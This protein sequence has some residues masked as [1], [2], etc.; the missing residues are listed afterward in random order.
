MA[1]DLTGEQLF[2]LCTLAHDIGSQDFE[3]GVPRSAVKSKGLMSLDLFSAGGS[4]MHYLRMELIHRWYQGWD[5][6]W[7]LKEIAKSLPTD[8]K[9]L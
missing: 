9:V 6:A 1:M 2:A 3:S 8:G 4:G 7:Q 5:E